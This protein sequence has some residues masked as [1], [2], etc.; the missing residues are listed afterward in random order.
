MTQLKHDA[1]SL[2]V[3]A[4]GECQLHAIDVEDFTLLPA[5]ALL[6]YEP[7]VSVKQSGCC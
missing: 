6:V 2:T 7:L 5:A 1:H 4:D 3:G